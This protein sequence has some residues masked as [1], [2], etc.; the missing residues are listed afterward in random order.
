MKSICNVCS[1]ILTPE[2]WA[3]SRAAKKDYLCTPC[4]NEKARN[5][6]KNDPEWA[7]KIRQYHRDYSN[8]RLKTE[9]RQAYEKE[10]AKKNQKRIKERN[11]AWRLKTTWGIT[12]EQFDQLLFKQGNCCAICKRKEPTG[13]GRWHVDRCH[14]SEKIRGL[15]CSKCN[16]GLGMFQD[17]ENILKAALNYLQK[18]P[19]EGIL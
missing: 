17:S 15:L 4:A 5:R 7:E 11:R 12:P 10:Y 18:P 13:V 3:K 16:H 14:K 1:K 2:V 19:S 9:D 6:R 8:T